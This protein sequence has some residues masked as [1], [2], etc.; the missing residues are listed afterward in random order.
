MGGRGR[1]YQTVLCDHQ[2][3]ACIKMG[4]DE[5]HFNVTLIMRDMQSQLESVHRP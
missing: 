5:S 3:D 4:S 1:L 2:N